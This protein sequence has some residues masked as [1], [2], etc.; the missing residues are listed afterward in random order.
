MTE[1]MYDQAKILL[2]EDDEE[3]RKTLSS[4]L[5]AHGYLVVECWDGID[6]VRMYGTSRTQSHEPAYSLVISDIR[7]PGVSG[8]EFLEG[9][10]GTTNSPPVIIITAF[11]DDETHIK[12]REFGAAAVL[13]KPFE[14]DTL[15]KVVRDTMDQTGPNKSCLS[16][17]PM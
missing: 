1:R 5:R 4:V 16:R 8:L 17:E 9:I 15:L 13:D 14:I 7:M 6:L 10:S 11:G 2:A 3:M 12:A